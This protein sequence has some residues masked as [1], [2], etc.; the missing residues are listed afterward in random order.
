MMV[1]VSNPINAVLFP[2]SIYFSASL[3][4]II[5]GVDY[6]GLILLTVYV[7][8][9]AVLFLFIVMLVNLKRLDHDR[10]SYLILGL[11]IL[12]ILTVQL[13]I[14]F[15]YRVIVYQPENLT[16]SLNNYSFLC[17]NDT[18]DA[19]RVNVLVRLG[20]LIFKEFPAYLFIAGLML[21]SA[22]IG[23]IYLTN[24][25]RGYTARRQYNQLS[26]NRH[27]YTVYLS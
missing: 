25:K 14:V 26:R 13:S 6:L 3:S 20:T 4:F 7:G 8:A 15:S 11:V 16:Y 12:F 27:I 10:T 9:I 21:L 19:Q 23:A 1:T 22:M 2:I 17:N 18:D 5:L 24:L